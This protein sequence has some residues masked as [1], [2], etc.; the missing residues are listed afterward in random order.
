MTRTTL[1]VLAHP[2][3]RSFC[4]NWADVS[5]EAAQ[6][7]P[8]DRVLWSDLYGM[9]FDPTE[10]PGHHPPVEAHFDV[11][12][13]QEAAASTALEP[14]VEK[15][16]DKIRT[17]ERVIFHF[18]IWWFGPPAILKGWLDRV[19]VHGELH[20]VENRFD[21]GL[22]RGKEALFCVTTGA[23][24]EESGFDGKEG[25][26][27]L[28]LWPLAQTLRYLGMDVLEPCVVNGVHGYFEGEAKQKLE[29][30]LKQVL[31]S[32]RKKISDWATHPRVKFNSDGDFDEQGRLRAD[33][34]S[35][36]A[37]IRHQE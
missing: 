19:L 22:C 17:A 20:D 4:G 14:D 3:R 10:G 29:V 32:H 9:K 23:S 21:T 6:D 18:P 27:R 1:I 8:A 13:A 16:V 15:E 11:L 30:R 7:D 12:K 31:A 28:L 25:D 33:A 26:T 5:A 36:S 35:H 24:A 37:F 2:E 34:P